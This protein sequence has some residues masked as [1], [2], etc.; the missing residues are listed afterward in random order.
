MI[1]SSM[2]E[3]TYP[4]LT[5]HILVCVPLPREKRPLPTD[6]LS[7]EER[8]EGW[9]LLRDRGDNSDTLILFATRRMSH[10]RV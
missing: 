3:H 2:N 1:I 4:V 9:V 8:G 10:L 7:S 6:D 5:I